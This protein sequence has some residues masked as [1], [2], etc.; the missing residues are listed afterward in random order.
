MNPRLTPLMKG[1][2]LEL[3]GCAWLNK[4]RTMVLPSGKSL[5]KSLTVSLQ[6][7]ECDRQTDGHRPMASTA[8][9]HIASRGKIGILFFSS[10]ALRRF[11]NSSPTSVRS[12]SVHVSCWCVSIDIKQHQ[13]SEL[14]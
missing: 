5:M 7:N 2:P 13:Y 14:H 8:P 9:T 12:L 3:C 11:S 6:H 4:S 10:S 1:F